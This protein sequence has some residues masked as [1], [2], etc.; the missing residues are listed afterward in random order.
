MATPVPNDR[1]RLAREATASRKYPGTSMGRTELAA[2]VAQW[3]EK[4][5]DKG[6]PHPFDAVHLGKEII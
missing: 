1:L 2:L 6:R 3:I 5:D 4:H